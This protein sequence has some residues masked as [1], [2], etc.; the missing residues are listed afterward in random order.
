MTGH[1][2]SRTFIGWWLAALVLFCFQVFSQQEEH[3]RMF[4]EQALALEAVS[5]EEAY[6]KSYDALQL[7]KEHE[8]LD[9]QAAVHSLLGRI[10]FNQGAFSQ[11]MKYYL[12]AARDFKQL[13]NQEQEVSNKVNLGK[14]YYY[15]KQGD[16]AKQLFKEAEQYYRANRNM[17]ALAAVL[18]EIG[19]LFEKS[20][21]YDSALIYENNALEISTQLGD[22]STVAMLYEN[23]GSILEDQHQLKE[24]RSY[25][26][27]A[28]ELNTRLNNKVA[29]VSNYNNV[30]DSYRK[31]KEEDS[32]LYY[33]N[34]ALLAAR[35]LELQYQESAA[36]RDLG[37]IYFQLGDAARAYNYQEEA[38]EIY[39]EL[40]SEESRR[41]MALLQTL[42]DVERKNNEI[43]VLENN[44]RM[45]KLQQTGLIFLAVSFLLFGGVVV[46]RQRLK[47][48]NNQLL[49]KQKEALHESALKSSALEASKLEVELEHKRLQENHLNLELE[50][51]Q[52]ALAARM[53]QL[54][55]KNKVLESVRTKIIAVVDDGT[56]DTEKT[57]LRNIANQ[58]AHNFQHDKAWDEF[59]TSFEKIHS[60]FFEKIKA[61]GADLTANDLRICALI[62]INLNSKD[63]SSLLGISSD[64]LR[65][66]RYRLRKKLNIETGENLRKFILKI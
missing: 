55:E 39:E 31:L 36:L 18:G 45:V 6:L 60:G 25:F 19:H 37:K 7:A 20:G 56:A 32:A 35:S 23:I 4:Y 66:A 53:L 57:D 30:G 26:L 15:I 12:L 61:G 62:R 21:R 46:S 64:S 52:K 10:F 42:F 27:K 34:A 41:Q 50:T 48:K 59:R 54:I 29:Q 58:I 14:V 43:V 11:S 44:Q 38:R 13:Q 16:K 22:S 8:Q 65:V 51:Q 49:L 63:I 28:L 40:Y 5:P 17:Q 2:K 47:I 24:A 9:L 33:T 1:K 3:T